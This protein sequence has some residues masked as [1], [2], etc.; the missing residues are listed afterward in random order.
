M[1]KKGFVLLETVVVLIVV[2]VSML[3]LYASYSFIFKNLEKS[4]Y[5][6]NIND[7]YRVNVFYKMIKS[8]GN[9]TV[10]NG[11]TIIRKS[12]CTAKLQ[13]SNCETLFDELDVEYLIYNDVRVNNIINKNTNLCAG[14]SSNQNCLNNTDINYMKTLE[15][16]YSYIIGVFS[17][18]DGSDNYY[19]C[20]LR[21]DD[22]REV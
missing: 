2:V 9:P 14:N 22:A 6:D 1:N 13:D 21:V 19:Y 10:E 16:N 8:A 5:Y 17:S 15:Q 18:D 7:V 3:G 4:K 12:N 20:S 11:Y